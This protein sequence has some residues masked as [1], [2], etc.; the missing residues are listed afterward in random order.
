MTDTNIAGATGTTSLNLTWGL[1][2]QVAM[3][4]QFTVRAQY[5]NL[6][7]FGNATSTSNGSLVSA[8]VIMNF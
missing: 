3:S 7:R 6:G 8:G 4:K 1:G 5:E 2:A